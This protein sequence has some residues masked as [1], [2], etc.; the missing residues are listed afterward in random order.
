M[1]QT[2]QLVVADKK[3]ALPFASWVRN[4][5]RPAMRDLLALLTRPGLL[6]FGH[7]LPAAELFPAEAYADATRTLLGTDQ[8]ALQYGTPCVRLKARVV[9]LMALRGVACSE[10]QIFLTA[11]AQHA[12]S[13]L[14]RLLLD[15]GSSLV[16]DDTVY[17][18]IVVVTQ[19][20]QPVLLT[21]PSRV[22]HGID[23]DAV[24]SLLAGGAR[25]RFIYVIPDG[26]NPTGASLPVEQRHRLVELSRTYGV[27]I[28]EDDPYGLLGFDGGYRPPLRA[29]DPERVLYVGSFSKIL[30]PSLRLGWIVAP[31]ELIPR[32]STVR[33]GSDMDVAS[34][35][36][37][38]V[39]AL[40]EGMD[41]GAHIGML[42]REYS[43]RM[44]AMLTALAKHFPPDATWHRPRGGMFTW[45]EL[46]PR[47]N[48]TALLREAV[49]REQVGFIPGEA[50]LSGA[51]SRATHSLRLTFSALQPER[52]AEGIE[53]L[54]RVVRRAC[55]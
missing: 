10:E 55:S 12:M 53:R 17:D 13:L 35:T 54:G 41:V 9:E 49:E 40:L 52:I 24:A 8:S 38:S 15:S 21:V 44:E 23:V 45:V 11:G 26:Q 25:P 27:P 50:F 34:L 29:L 37:R 19:P 42:R 22:P 16:L 32:L 4:Y 18:G 5:R 14:A 30:A 39:A 46:P 51:N 47:V 33:Q 7:V 3:F 28:I 48:A 36:Q 2:E 43:L 31:A 6:S 1:S 20:F